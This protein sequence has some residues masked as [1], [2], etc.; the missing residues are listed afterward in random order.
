MRVTG[1]SSNYNLSRAVVATSGMEEVVKCWSAQARD[2]FGFFVAA[3]PAV[4]AASSST[5]RASPRRG[6]SPALSRRGNSPRRSPGRARSLAKERRGASRGKD[7]N[8][9]E[10]REKD[11]RMKSPPLGPDRRKDSAAEINR[12][13]NRERSPILRREDRQDDERRGGGREDRREDLKKREEEGK[14]RRDKDW[15]ERRG[16]KGGARGSSRGGNTIDDSRDLKFERSIDL[17]E[18]LRRE[19]IMREGS[20]LGGPRR[21]RGGRGMGRGGGRVE[22]E[23]GWRNRNFQRSRSRD[24]QMASTSSGTK[25]E[26]YENGSKGKVGERR[27]EESGKV[28]TED[29][30]KEETEALAE[31]FSDFGDSDDDILNQEDDSKDDVKEGDSKT[32]SRSGSPRGGIGRR[33]R[34]DQGV[35]DVLG[36]KGE[37]EE[38]EIVK[39]EQEAVVKS[40]ARLADALGADWSVLLKPK[41]ERKERE[42]GAA[43]KRWSGAEIFRRIGLSKVDIVDNVN[44]TL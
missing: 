31:D 5:R 24:R 35:L 1:Y 19:R 10:D 40:N 43:R 34:G 29:N 4:R 16:G 20:P 28:E 37:E 7:R 44:L 39:G 32:S 21:G 11:L 6:V 15:E 8:R 14:A 36:K 17:K 22:L 2:K 3:Q 30:S 38:E 25:G 18:E 9:K 23:E 13:K 33:K 41:E 42:E 27:E 26:S 12:G